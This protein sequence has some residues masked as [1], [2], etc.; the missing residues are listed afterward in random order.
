MPRTA[1]GLWC[2]RTTWWR[3]AA[4]SSQSSPPITSGAQCLLRLGVGSSLL[5]SRSIQHHHE[6]I[7]VEHA[8]CLWPPVP[9]MT[10][11]VL[12]IHAE[13]NQWCKGDL[14]RPD[15]FQ[16]WHQSVNHNLV[17]LYNVYVSKFLAAVVEIEVWHLLQS[18][19][20]NSI[21]DV[22]FNAKTSTQCSSMFWHYFLWFQE[23][24]KARLASR[25][26]FPVGEPS[27]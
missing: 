20:Y 4:L 8:K 10:W 14:P 5:S 26:L 1:W 25:C 19:D 16:G 6:E 17:L 18:T 12:G 15:I 9:G 27:S 3:A 2:S 11:C 22:Q 7:T 24:G 21:S 23:A 13:V